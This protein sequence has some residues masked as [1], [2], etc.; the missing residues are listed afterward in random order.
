VPN[1]GEQNE[2]RANDRTRHLGCLDGASTVGEF[3]DE[4]RHHLRACPQTTRCTDLAEVGIEQLI[5]LVRGSP[6]REGQQRQLAGGQGWGRRLNAPNMTAVL[7]GG[8]RPMCG[9]LDRAT[10]KSP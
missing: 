5:D 9:A 3:A 2:L 7:C 10:S 6:Y 8:A 1:V 4:S